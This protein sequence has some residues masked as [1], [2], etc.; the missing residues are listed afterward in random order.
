MD[1]ELDSE[2]LWSGAWEDMTLPVPL[3]ASLLCLSPHAVGQL[4]EGEHLVAEQRGNFRF[5]TVASLFAYRRRHWSP[6]R[7]ARYNA[8]LDDATALDQAAEQLAG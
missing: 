3:A 7:A 5:V 6:E 8:A 1:E 2:P 4:I